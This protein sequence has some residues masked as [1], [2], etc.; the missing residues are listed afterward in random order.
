VSFFNR[1]FRGQGQPGE[2]ESPG[3]KE[4]WAEGTLPPVADAAEQIAAQ[5]AVEQAMQPAAEESKPAVLPPAPPSRPK[6][7]AEDLI[8]DALLRQTEGVSFCVLHSLHE[9]GLRRF[10]QFLLSTPADIAARAEVSEELASA[11]VARFQR[12]QNENPH[13][14][15]GTNPLTDLKELSKLAKALREQQAL[16][17]SAA[18]S[19]TR[20]A[21]ADK[22]NIRETRTDLLLGVRL[23]L[24]R[25]GEIDFIETLERLPARTAVA[26]LI[27]F[28]QARAR[29]RAENPKRETL[30]ND[31]HA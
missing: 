21:L 15:A 23:C 1:V 3:D 28:L 4:E 16:Y 31:N 14:L 20:Q 7:K 25:L 13:P 30:N 18:L 6:A 5:A 10:D 19:W 29:A 11:I 8:V 22:R 9:A 26:E 17:E 12:Y 24:A 2:S 27:A